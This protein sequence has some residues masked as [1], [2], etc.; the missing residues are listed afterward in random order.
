MINVSTP[1]D[2]E[3]RDGPTA[4]SRLMLWID[5]V[6]AYLL[7]LGRRVSIGGPAVDDHPAEIPLLANLSRRHATFVR[8]GDVYVL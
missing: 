2:R 4:Q 5:G 6:G 8:S 7:C 1:I 3:R